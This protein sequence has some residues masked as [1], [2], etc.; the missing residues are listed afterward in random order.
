MG[1]LIIEIITL[2]TPKRSLEDIVTGKVPSIPKKI[3][4]QYK[5]IEP[6]I[7]LTQKCCDIDPSKRPK[8][9]EILDQLSWLISVK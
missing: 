9:Q 5:S 6:I 2:Q 7:Q 1:I 4:E 8:Y 3:M